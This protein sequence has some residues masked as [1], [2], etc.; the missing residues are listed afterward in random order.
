MLGLEVGLRLR[1]CGRLRFF[2]IGLARTTGIAPGCH[3]SY[4]TT[5]HCRWK[6]NPSMRSNGC[7]IRISVSCLR[8]T[9]PV[10]LLVS[11]QDRP[12]GIKV[13]SKGL[14]PPWNLSRFL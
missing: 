9:G 10:L 13:N 3:E 14:Y 4:Y 8:N 5:A 12:F 11:M 1:D 7:K 2:D 6:G